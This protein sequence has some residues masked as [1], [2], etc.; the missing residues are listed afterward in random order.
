ME[1]NVAGTVTIIEPRRGWVMVNGRELYNYR[2]NSKVFIKE[3]PNM[4]KVL[5]SH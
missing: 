5:K 1:Q 2:R 4:K 3:R